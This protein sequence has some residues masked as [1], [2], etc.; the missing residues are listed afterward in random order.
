MAM[1]DRNR[2]ALRSIPTVITSSHAFTQALDARAR[3]AG[4][5][6][7]ERGNPHHAL[8]TVVELHLKDTLG[9][10]L[11]AGDA[12]DSSWL[13]RRDIWGDGFNAFDVLQHKIDIPLVER[14]RDC[15][16][17]AH[18]GFSVTLYAYEHDFGRGEPCSGILWL[19]HVETL[20]TPSLALAL[21][22]AI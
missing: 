15:V 20:V 1:T 4:N 9:V 11:G 22:I 2:N 21:R 18:V 19:D 7:W 10:L 12:P 13:S 14:L 17:G 3:A 8:G 5:R 6:F 16:S